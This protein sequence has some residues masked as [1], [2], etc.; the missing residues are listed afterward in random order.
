MIFFII[1]G[2]KNFINSDPFNVFSSGALRD[3]LV[4]LSEEGCEEGDSLKFLIKEIREEESKNE[5]KLEFFSNLLS[6][7]GWFKSLEEAIDRIINSFKSLFGE[8]SDSF[9]FAVVD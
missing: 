7:C 8:I 4:A 3:I 1:D 6:L 2:R 9:L 5:L